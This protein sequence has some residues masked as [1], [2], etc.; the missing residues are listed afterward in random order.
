MNVFEAVKENVTT[1]EA[2]RLYGIKVNRNGMAVCP[3]HD[4]KNPSLK[5]DKRFH[6]FGCQ[7]DG[8]AV[9]F[10]SQLYGLSAKEAAVKL[11]SD[12]GLMYSK[13]AKPSIRKQL[14]KPS[15]EEQERSEE[16]HAFQVLS[17]YY[18]TL[19]DWESAYAPRSLEEAWHPKFEEALQ[20]KGYVEYMLD[21][22]LSGTP[23][24]KREIVTQQREEVRKLE[25]RF[26]KRRAGQR[27]PGRQPER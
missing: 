2:A 16:H 8:D 5:L 23:E 14:R 11:A 25:K 26:D 7:A 9:D 27:S 24:E 12:F 22:L 3:F 15:I 17:G 18:H 21:T 19:R 6:C 4:D 13:N 1:L 10:V 20:R